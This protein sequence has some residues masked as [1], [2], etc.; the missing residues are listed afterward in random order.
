VIIATAGHIDHGKTLLVKALTGID[1][2]RLPE[3]KQRGLTIDLGFAYLPINGGQTIGFVDVPGHERFIRN[4]L[5]GVSGIDLALLIVAADDGPM[6]QTEEHLAILDILDVRRGAVVITKIDRVD[7]QRV[8]EVI[9]DTHVLLAGTSLEDAAIFKVSALNGKGILDLRSYLEKAAQDTPSRVTSGGFRLA[10]DRNFLMKGAG[11]VVTGTVFA[12]AARPGDRLLITPGGHEVRV[13]SIHAQNHEAKSGE[14]GQRCALNLTGRGIDRETIS[15]GDWLV[16]PGLNSPSRRFDARLKVLA[17]ETRPLRHWTPVHVHAG[18]AAL[19]GRVALLEDRFLSPGQAA[20]VQIVLDSPT[21]LVFGDRFVVRDQS[22]RRTIGGGQVI[23][24]F[25]PGRGRRTAERLKL[26]KA[27]YPESPAEAL[28]GMCSASSDGINIERF[29]VA[30]NLSSD[31]AAGIAADAGLIIASTGGVRTALTSD[32]WNCLRSGIVKSINVHHTGT[33]DSRGMSIEELCVSVGTRVDRSL[34]EAVTADLIGA[35]KL[36]AEGGLLREAGH[37]VK[38]PP[39]DARLWEIVR[40]ALEAEEGR[41]PSVPDLAATIGIDVRRLEQFLVRLGRQGLTVQISRN[42]F[43]TPT[44][45]WKLAEVAEGVASSTS[46]QRFTVRSFRDK[47]ELGRNLTIEVLEFFDRSG[48]TRRIGDERSVL[49]PAT[50]A[51]TRLNT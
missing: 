2:D 31:D 23:D 15:R 29:A 24:P 6:P 11:L 27:T 20:L 12:G 8:K 30:R 35:G 1:A 19:T 26:L 25:A 13:R 39:Q 10:I 50:D 21:A 45:I 33:S 5:A 46:N 14:A 38:L 34:L 17:T 28:Q 16:A 36:I 48:F 7:Q 4:M 9:D 18:A 22:A 3:E 47:T 44:M 51:F 42:R 43:M 37:Q 49:K 32:H 41:P 40:P